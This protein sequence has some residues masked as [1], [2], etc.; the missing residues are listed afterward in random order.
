MYLNQAILR[1]RQL[2]NPG[3]NRE[4]IEKQKALLSIWENRAPVQPH[5][6]SENTRLQRGLLNTKDRGSEV[7]GRTVLRPSASGAQDIA[8][9]KELG[10]WMG[11]CV[12]IVGGL[13]L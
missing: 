5:P 1:S 7:L 2:G 6:Q 3:E 10:G 4:T 11:G 9:Y 8:R 12:G 13:Q